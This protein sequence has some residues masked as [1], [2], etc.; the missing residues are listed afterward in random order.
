L[1]DRRDDLLARIDSLPMPTSA[2]L[3]TRHHGDYHLGQVLINENDFIITDFEGE[4]ARTLE[5]RRRKHTPLRDVAGMLRSFSYAA[6]AALEKV[7]ESPEDQARLAP[8]ALQ[9]Q[10]E[11]RTAF[12]NAYDDAA[13]NAGIYASTADMHALIAFF[14]LEKALYELRYEINNRPDW[15]RT[16]LNGILRLLA[17][18]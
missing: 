1:L 17:P 11:A 2:V 14:E 6:A 7:I 10:A 16:P 3:K 8:L 13:R 18:E 5:E 12:I 9:W 15:V 4:P